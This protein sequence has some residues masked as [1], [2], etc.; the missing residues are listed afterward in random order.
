[1]KDYLLKAP[2]APKS[3]ISAQRW[4]ALLLVLLAFGPKGHCGEPVATEAFVA[5]Q[6]TIT[7]TVTDWEGVPLSA[8]TVYEK[9]TTN[10][11]YTDFDGKYT[12]EIQGDAIL[13]FS[14]VG[15]RKQ[16]IPTN[17]STTINAS[18]QEDRSKLDEVV[19]T[20]YMTQRK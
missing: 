8:V 5:V 2:C 17:G 3:P 6:R 9:G 12:L 7:G 16:E 10:G 1:M 19:I 13:V 14:F 15:F 20:G 18:M 4:V 11:T